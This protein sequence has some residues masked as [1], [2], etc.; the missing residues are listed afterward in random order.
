MHTCSLIVVAIFLSAFMKPCSHLTVYQE[1]PKPNDVVRVDLTRFGGYLI[2]N[3]KGDPLCHQ[4]VH[5][6]QP[7]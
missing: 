1:S 4:H 2:S 7:S 3:Q 5:L 6:I